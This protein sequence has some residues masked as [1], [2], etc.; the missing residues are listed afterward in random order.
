VALQ[1]IEDVTCRAFEQIRDADSGVLLRFV[2]G[3]DTAPRP[4]TPE[5]MATE[6][7]DPFA[8][9]VLRRGVFPETADELL[10]TIDQETTEGDSLRHERSFMLGEDSQLAVQTDDIESTNRSIRFL[11]ARGDA[12]HGPELIISASHPRQGLVEIMA[13]DTA[14]DGFNFY[15]TVREASGSWVWAGNSRH[16]LQPPTRGRG[17]FES[18]PSGNLI[19]KELKFP[20][21]HWD[22]FKAHISPEVFDEQDIRRQHPWFL[23]KSGAETCE[24]AV[25]MPSIVRWTNVQFEQLAGGSA[26]LAPVQLIEHIVTCPTVNLASSGTESA[27]GKLG[28]AIDLPPGF[29]VDVDG[30]SVVGLQPPPPVS[31]P[32]AIYLSSLEEFGFK[33]TVD[34]F[35]Q[36]GDTHFAFIVPERAFEDTEVLRQAVSRGVISPRL[37]ACLLMVD[38]PNPVFS[39]SRAQLLDHVPSVPEADGGDLS[40]TIA[41]SLIA[42]SGPTEEGSPERDFAQRWSVGDDGWKDA[43]D[44]ELSGYYGAI[45]A[46]TGTQE[47]FND[48][49][50]LSESRRN[51]FRELPLFEFPP[52]FPETN[53]PREHLVMTSEGIVEEAG[54]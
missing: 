51:D 36:P 39:R 21:V 45:Q 5:E 18:H 1:P 8:T 43:F 47:G 13:W 54:G 46:R 3:E 31:V 14:H 33:L 9:L 2:V 19:M 53:L 12:A 4:M 25:V 30:L 41:Q 37:A 38:F 24:T 15:R 48:Y 16:A 35:S 26:T 28:S 32:P 27:A 10:A 52:L 42:A 50:R 20:W 44:S 23:N 17:P 6:L 29:L 34:T 22:S 49:V 40:E 7:G 11:V